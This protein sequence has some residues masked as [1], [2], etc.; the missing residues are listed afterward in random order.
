MAIAQVFLSDSK[1]GRCSS[2][3]EMRLPLVV[4]LLISI[5]HAIFEVSKFVCFMVKLDI[6]LQICQRES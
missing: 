1:S 2:S 3:S 5:C 4:L 6:F